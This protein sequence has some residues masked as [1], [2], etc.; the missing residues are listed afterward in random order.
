MY[1][2][3]DYKTSCN[4]EN[5][6]SSPPSAVTEL[7]SFQINTHIFERVN[8]MKITALFLVV[9][10]LGCAAV[11]SFAITEAHAGKKMGGTTK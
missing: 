4:F 3:G 11:G 6:N 8:T 7:V 9:A 10:A 5:S 2:V 1:I